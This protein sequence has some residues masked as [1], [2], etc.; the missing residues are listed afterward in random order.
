MPA[1]SVVV[2]TSQARLKHLTKYTACFFRKFYNLANTRLRTLIERLELAQCSVEL[3][4]NNQQQN[5]KDV[6]KLFFL[7]DN[8]VR[9]TTLM[10]R[11]LAYD[12][13]R[14]FIWPQN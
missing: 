2:A 6:N 13:E 4:L 11:T 5:N 9:K 10:R 3:F 14:S 7:K 8:G 12:R 1:G